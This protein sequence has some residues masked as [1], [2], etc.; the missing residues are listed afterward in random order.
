MYRRPPSLRISKAFGCSNMI[1]WRGN[2]PPDWRVPVPR[3]ASGKASA[4]R[5]SRTH[6]P[7]V[8]RLAQANLTRAVSEQ[9]AYRCWGKIFKVGDQLIEGERIVL[10]LAADGRHGDGILGATDFQYPAMIGPIELVETG[11][12]WFPI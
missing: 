9:A 1:A 10:P 6:P 7:H 12:E 2:S 3:P 4:V 11:I 8:F 5:R